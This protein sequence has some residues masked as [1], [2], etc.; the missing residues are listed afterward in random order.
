MEIDN[1]NPHLCIILSRCLE[2]KL[3]I[4]TEESDFELTL[5]TLILSYLTA[6]EIEVEGPFV[7]HPIS[8]LLE[9]L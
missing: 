5:R 1:V 9:V 8:F 4:V 7:L 2:L 3:T 6:V